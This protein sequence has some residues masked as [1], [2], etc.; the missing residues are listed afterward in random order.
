MTE[1]DDELEDNEDQDD[2]DDDEVSNVSTPEVKDRR[3]YKINQKPGD[4]IPC[5]KCRIPFEN[6]RK[7]SGHFTDKHPSLKLEDFKD[8]I[9]P[10]S[11][12]EL[13]S[14]SSSK[15]QVAPKM[16]E[17]E[18]EETAPEIGDAARVRGTIKR[19]LVQF[20]KLPE[21]KRTELMSERE[22]LATYLQSLAPKDVS[23]SDIRAIESDVETTIA[24]RFREASEPK[25]AENPDSPD[26]SPKEMDTELKMKIQK[27]RS[28][29]K[30]DLQKIADMP[31]GL[32][33]SIS[34]EKDML[35][36]LNRK[37][38][39]EDLT[40]KDVVDIES[41]Y[42]S[43]QPYI[44]AA[45]KKAAKS[46]KSESIDE[47]DEDEEDDLEEARQMKRLKRQARKLELKAEIRAMKLEM[48]LG[49]GGPMPAAP[50]PI[51]VPRPKIDPTTKQQMVDENGV[52]I[53]EMTYQ[54]PLSQDPI[55]QLMMQFMLEELKSKRGGDGSSN[56]D[57]ILLEMKRDEL[58]WKKEFMEMQYKH[59]DT[60]QSDEIKELRRSTQTLIDQ[61]HQREIEQ[62]SNELEQ[63]R[64]MI[65]RDP[66]GNLLAEKNRLI[67]L[68][69]VQDPA[70]ARSL[71]AQE[72]SLQYSKEALDKSVAKAD[73]FRDDLK[74]IAAPLFQVQTEMMKRQVERADED[75]RSKGKPTAQPQQPTMSE[76]ERI[77]KWR[78][79]QQ[80]VNESSDQIS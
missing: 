68:G 20:A 59:K 57:K 54:Y 1:E 40:K 55:Q 21:N 46:T 33:E 63:T 69:I 2:P 79:I 29:I 9:I 8:Q 24:P 44:D 49:T 58:E 27:L 14:K 78:K 66:I 32:Q 73:A 28:N 11:K 30:A 48:G 34:A 10:V 74:E 12:K 77:E 75:A 36:T 76:E 15:P 60:G 50:Q 16:S 17:E 42:S 39:K 61:T 47:E 53:T 26:A 6:I 80:A 7:L 51:M 56:T 13:K 43:Y 18:K 23:Y 35:I 45:T 64:A 37:L 38:C 19:L 72:Q 3:K 52:P 62:I 22:A 25:P 67:S 4:V 31:A 5:P 65:Q 70:A 41:T 71:S